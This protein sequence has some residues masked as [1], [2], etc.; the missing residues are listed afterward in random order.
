MQARL[1]SRVGSQVT[2]KA[3][4]A[5]KGMQRF[6]LSGAMSGSLNRAFSSTF[7]DRAEVSARAVEIVKKF[8]NVEESKVSPTCHFTNDLGLDS[9]DAVEL[10]MGFEEEF[11]VEIPDEEAEKIFTLEDVV[12]YISAHPMAK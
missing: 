12:T 9:L 6:Q 8:P 4:P 3:S 11:A 5:F 1:F 7:L 10:I 2:S